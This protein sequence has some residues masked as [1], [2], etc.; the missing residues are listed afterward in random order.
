MQALN[1][2]RKTKWVSET[3]ISIFALAII[4]YFERVRFIL[5]VPSGADPGNWLTGAWEI[6]GENI[7]L[8]GWT[9]PPLSL[10]LLRGLLFV[11]PPLLAVK[12]LGVLSY[13]LGAVLFF[14]MI[15]LIGCGQNSIM[16]LGITVLIFL[17]GYFGEVFAW[18]GYPQLL[19]TSFL[20]V[21]FPSLE[22][23]LRDG[24]IGYFLLSVLS[25]ALVVYSNHFIAIIMIVFLSILALISLLRSKADWKKTMRRWVNFSLIVLFLIIPAV[26]IYWKFYAL[27]DA[28]PAN[29]QNF[30]FSNIGML[31]FL[32][33]QGQHWIWIF[34]MV[35][36]VWT[37]SKNISDY[38]ACTAIVFVPTSLL[39]LFLTREMRL[40]QLIILGVGYGLVLVE[41]KLE[42]LLKSAGMK[43]V[44][45]IVFFIFMTTSLQFSKLWFLN[46]SYY[47][48]VVDSDALEG[49]Q[50]LSAN[51]EAHDV[52]AASPWKPFSIGW[53]VE[54]YAKRPCLYATDPRW[55]TFSGERRNV[56]IANDLFSE[57][58]SLDAILNIVRQ[59]RIKYVLIDKTNIPL[60]LPIIS[61]GNFQ[62]VFEN[63]RV[64]V[65]KTDVQR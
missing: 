54:G 36:V 28:L 50:W 35:V 18:G 12:I 1:F 13:F 15:R 56:A 9:Y 20:A 55:L 60:S 27:A 64:L 31:F 17:S 62:V 39:L 24:Q 52:V 21:V 57:D 16:H 29:P 5:N 4:F 6:G 23:W 47:Y 59:N 43:A 26:V 2:N 34:L 30:S 48:Q 19:A 42:T 8:V 58:M 38:F 44:F 63:A 53:W 65:L 49:L 41:M 32:S 33:F 51:T 40:L 25:A 14:L 10:V 45:V 61:W 11:F 46:R 7:R 3:I 22:K 37:A